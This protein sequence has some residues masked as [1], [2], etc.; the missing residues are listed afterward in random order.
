MDPSEMHHMEWYFGN[1]SDDLVVPKYQDP[2]ERFLSADYWL[3]WG[4]TT[5][6][7]F[8]SADTY[9][10]WGTN[11]TV[12]E[13]N[14]DGQSLHDEV[15]KENSA[16]EGELSSDSN[17]CGGFSSVGQGAERNPEASSHRTTRLD[18][19][20]DYQ[21]DG[22][23][24]MDQ[25]DDIFLSLLLE[26]EMPGMENLCRPACIFPESQGSTMPPDNLLTDMIADTCSIS[27]DLSGL[28]SSKHLKT[29]DF[30]PTGWVKEEDDPLH[31]MSPN[32]EK[33]KGSLT[34]K[35]PL[36]NELNPS[37]LNSP[38]K[39]NR[40]V[41]EETPLE[42]S[43]LQELEMAMTQLT[44]KT[45]FYFRDAFYRLAKNSEQQCMII[46]RKSGEIT[47]EEPAFS[48]VHNPTFR[49]GGSEHSQSETN[50]INRTIVNLIFNNL[51]V[52]A[53]D[54]SCIASVNLCKEA[55]ATTGSRNYSLNQPQVVPQCPPQ[56]L[57]GDSEVAFVGRENKTTLNFCKELPQTDSV[58]NMT[59]I[60]EF[61]E[62]KNLVLSTAVIPVI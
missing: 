59:R 50:A 61:I 25:T 37:E 26:E 45:R 57:P 6:E 29:R 34:L 47:M 55:I 24:E 19:R 52:D 10:V 53:K 18:D 15:D 30:P 23:A 46:Q 12:D 54:L 43:V 39:A 36:V 56:I 9:C 22:L 14:F 44:Q 32:S 3:Q 27:R 16:L 48:M 38:C 13:L 1:E 60:Q 21:L 7:S 28:G 8:S 42:E 35:A 5:P 58:R 49:L 20:P 33:M 2:S 40:H 4:I 11:L 17:R 41:N 51:N 31:F 62:D